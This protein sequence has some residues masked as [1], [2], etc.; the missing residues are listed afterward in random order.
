MYEEYDALLN[1]NTWHLVP[2]VHGQNM[3]DCTWV[4][5]VKTKSDGTVD[6]YKARL[7]E[8]GFKQLYGIDYED[9][10]SPC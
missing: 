1:K 3:I 7:V 2:S 8:K 5:E 10:F 6:R 9:T 4:Y